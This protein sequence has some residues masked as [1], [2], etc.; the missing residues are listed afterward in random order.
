MGSS[1]TPE[2]IPAPRPESIPPGHDVK[3]L[4]PSDSS[5]SGSDMAG[6]GLIDAD[7]MNLDRGTNADMDFGKDD[8]ADAGTSVGDL[9][10]DETSDRAGT[11]T[12]MSADLEPRKGDAF[13]IDTDAVVDAAGAGLGGG[14]DEAEEAQLGITNEELDEALRTVQSGKGKPGNV[15]SGP[16]AKS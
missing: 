14:L 8:I 2:N 13:D 4:G 10:M 16:R 6:P 3:S 5:D 7:M 11:G 12:R 1:L 9:N 15:R